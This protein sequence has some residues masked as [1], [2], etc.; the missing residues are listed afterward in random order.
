MKK[1]S[2]LLFR[3][4]PAGQDGVTPKPTFRQKRGICCGYDLP[5]RRVCCSDVSPQGKTA[6]RFGKSFILRAI[7]QAY[8]L[9]CLRH[10]LR[11]RLRYLCRTTGRI[12]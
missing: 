9:C 5:L 3:R 7:R 12:R 6:E 1:G 10:V 8:K 4:L 11:C 2:C